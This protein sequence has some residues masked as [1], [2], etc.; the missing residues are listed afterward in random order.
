MYSH[1]TRHSLYLFVGCLMLLS[2]FSCKNEQDHKHNSLAQTDIAS[3]GPDKETQVMIDSTNRAR[4]EVDPSKVSFYLTKE[5]AAKLKEAFPKAQGVEQINLYLRYGFEELK[6]GNSEQAI[7]VFSDIVDRS[8][9]LPEEQQSTFVYEVKK[10][11]ALSYLR[12]GE[13]ENCILNHTIASCIIPIIEEGQHSKPEGSEAAVQ[14]FDELMKE[15]PDDQT[16]RYLYN[17]GMMTLGK[18]PHE[19]PSAYRLPDGFFTEVHDFPRFQDIAPGLGI[20]VSGLAGGVAIED[21]NR[22]GLLDVMASSWGF[23][24]QVRLFVRQEDG[25]F[26]DVTEKAGLKGVTGGLNMQHADYNNDGYTDVLILRGAWFSGE[27]KFPNSLLRNN[28]DGTFTDVAISAGIFSRRPTQTATWADFDLD[29]WLDLFIGNESTDEGLFPC[30]LFHNN[31]DGTFTD[32]AEQAG[33]ALKGF[34]KGVTAGD[35]NNDG[36]PDLYISLLNH[37]N[38]LL[39]NQSQTGRIQFQNLTDEAGVHEPVVSFP[40]WMFDYNNDGYLDIFVSSYT[41]ATTDLPYLLLK[42]YGNTMNKYRPRLYKNNSDG[43]FS[44]VSPEQGLTE[45]AFTMGSNFGDL[46][47]DGFLDFFLGTGEPNLMSVVPNKTYLNIEGRAFKDVTYS[48][49]FGNIQK[50]H[51]VGFADFDLDGDQDIYVVMGGAFEGDIYQNI[52]FE[53]PLGSKNNWCIVRLEGVKA[54]RSAIGARLVLE[55]EENGKSR[56]IHRM[57]S[58]GS[59]FG[60]NS[61][62]E[63]IGLGKASRIKELS[64]TWPHKQSHPQ[65]FRDL[66]VNAVYFLKEGEGIQELS[67][68]PVPFKKSDPKHSH[69]AM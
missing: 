49:G 12:L 58:T 36:Y 35:V 52:L 5:R 48:G 22:D 45:P 23:R 32:I 6:A 47:N 61:L 16:C 66:D 44:D 51:G 7:Q 9:N 69:H 14:L 21:F 15:R 19:I 29:G 31:Q 3:P 24:D 55:I 41:E 11:L 59:S 57:I 28:G 2:F 64:V 17:I 25:S 63:E 1:I 34:V 37:H 50:G 10:L 33:M 38:F 39:L 68:Q 18:F 67:F 53:N 13:Q 62:Q 40:T 60:G 42:D 4:E 54:N 65:A 56:T 46:D 27:G 20:S 8:R 30:E 43:S 26:A